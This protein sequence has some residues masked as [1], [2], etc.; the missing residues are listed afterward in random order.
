M[1]VLNLARHNMRSICGRIFPVIDIKGRLAICKRVEW[2]PARMISFPV[3]K[4]EKE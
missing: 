1:A 3:N 2:F 4:V